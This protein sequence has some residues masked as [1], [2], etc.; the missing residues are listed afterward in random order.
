MGIMGSLGGALFKYYLAKKYG[1][2]GVLKFGKY[3][4]F[5]EEKLHKMETFFVK[6]GSFSTFISRLIP[7]V[8]Q[9][10]SLPAGLSNMDMKKFVLYTTMGAGIWVTLLSVLGYY[11]GLLV[12]NIETTKQI[13]EVSEPYVH[14][15][16]YIVLGLLS[17]ATFFYIWR[18]N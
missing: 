14:K 16:L 3:F 5:T 7:A 18:D 12:E 9:F 15:I 10:I 11:I 4:F 17:I 13:L 8:R 6:H 2:I 1:R